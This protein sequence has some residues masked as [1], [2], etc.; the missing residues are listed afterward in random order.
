MKLLLALAIH[1]LF[2]LTNTNGSKNET[3]YES[4]GPDFYNTK[5]ILY[6]NSDSVGLILPLSVYIVRNLKGEK[7]WNWHKIWQYPKRVSNRTSQMTRLT[8]KG[9]VLDSSSIRHWKDACTKNVIG[10]TESWFITCFKFLVWGFDQPSTGWFQDRFRAWLH[11]RI[12]ISC[13]PYW[14]LP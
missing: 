9:K 6:R 3:A 14:I 13:G 2:K 7:L 5:I 8:S 1:S 11:I 12:K 10:S 4:H